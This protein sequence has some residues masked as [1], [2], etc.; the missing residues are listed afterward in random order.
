VL[1]EVDGGEGPP[2]TA[3]WL[4]SWLAGQ[5]GWRK[6]PGASA[7]NSFEFEGPSGVV[8]AVVETRPGE[9]GSPSRLAEVA[10]ELRPI[11]GDEP[12]GCKPGQFL[13][14]KQAGG[15]AI[16]VEVHSAS[17]CELPRLVSAP[18]D[19]VDRRVAAALQSY[20]SDPPYE[21]ALPIF[22]ELSGE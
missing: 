19:L 2:R 11:P 5:L 17:R 12:S 9:P 16:R 6:S 18:P 22:R 10:I 4:I 8:A 21:R 20:L 1:V 3:L 14:R 7:G 13:L 15:S